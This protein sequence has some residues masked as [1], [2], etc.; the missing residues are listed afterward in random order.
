MTSGQKIL[1]AVVVGGVLYL[2]LSKRGEAGPGAVL[3]VGA[4][5][6][7]MGYT[8]DMLKYGAESKIDPALLAG[9]M[10][11]E[12]RGVPYAVGAAGEIGLMQILPSTGL[13][14]NNAGAA[15]LQRPGINIRT[16]AK[17]L[18]YCI[19]RKRGN[20]LAGI[21]GY[22]YGPDRVRIEGNR[23][24]A[25]ESVLRYAQ[26]VLS[27]A[28]QYKK[29]FSERMGFFYDS[30]FPADVLVLSGSRAGCSKCF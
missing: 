7:V 26:T 6:R 15:E 23:V 14:I 10:T 21:A 28:R 29:L 8:A 1:A 3:P 18:R 12:S 24:I 19:D 22:N 20:A 2:L 9:V 27:Y 17:Y 4:A 5:D 11:I 30:A 16:G 25:P 13:W